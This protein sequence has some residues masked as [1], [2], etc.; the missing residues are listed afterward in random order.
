MIDN[1]G[2]LATNKGFHLNTHLNEGAGSSLVRAVV[3][4]VGSMDTCTQTL[5]LYKTQHHQ[6]IHSYSP[7]LKKPMDN[8]Y[9]YSNVT[10]W[11]V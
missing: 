7:R 10:L 2:R 8:G 6:V 4:V 9:I 11:V 3:H 1:N 5:E